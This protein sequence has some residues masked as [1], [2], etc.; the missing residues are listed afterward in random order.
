MVTKFESKLFLTKSKNLKHADLRSKNYLIYNDYEG[1][2]DK[3]DEY[4]ENKEFDE[5]YEP[6]EGEFD[7]SNED[8]E[9][10]E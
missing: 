9:F 1:N 7:D 6:K 5:D 4:S 2:S 8:N 10:D 3:S